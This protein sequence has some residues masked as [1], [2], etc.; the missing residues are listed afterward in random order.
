MKDILFRDHNFTFFFF[1]LVLLLGYIL[2]CH[3]P[4]KLHCL[5]LQLFNMLGV[6]V[7]QVNSVLRFNLNLVR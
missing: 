1:L 4:W 3:H 2:I 6:G 7:F 5:Y